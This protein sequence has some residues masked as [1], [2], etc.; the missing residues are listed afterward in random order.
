MGDV[1]DSYVGVGVYTVTSGGTP[2]TTDA[3]F[4]DDITFTGGTIYLG[5]HNLFLGKACTLITPVTASGEPGSIGAGSGYFGFHSSTNGTYNSQPIGRLCREVGPTTLGPLFFPV[6]PIDGDMPG[7]KYVP[8]RVQIM[9]FTPPFSSSTVPF[10]H[11]AVRPVGIQHP[12]NLQDKP[13]LH[14]YWEVDGVGT[15]DVICTKVDMWY[16]QHYV[17]SGS[18]KKAFSARYYDNIVYNNVFGSGWDPTGIEQNLNFSSGNYITVGPSN[19]PSLPAN[20]CVTEFGDY[21][22]G[23]GYPG[24]DPIPVELTSFSARYMDGRVDLNWQTAT[25]LNNF[26]FAIE[27]SVD[28]ENWEE[29]G[30]VQGFGTSSS[31][32]SYAHSDYLRDDLKHLP[33]LAYRLRQMDRD[34][35]TDYSNIVFVKTGELPEGVKLYAAYP[36]PFNPTT[37][38]SFAIGNPADVTLRIYNTLGQNVATLLR[39]SAM[40]A[41][42]HTV[43]FNGDQL[44]SGIYMAVLEANGEVQHQ[45]LVLN[46]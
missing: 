23:F 2:F 15:P 14:L 1:S 18:D 33:Q 38:I 24:G 46:K 29:V 28:K 43:P 9:S 32:K 27:R 21:T 16:H 19:Y 13:S 22:I 41:G 35:T 10:P 39:G 12:A 31:P 40:D 42:L 17:T 6:A 4:D 30:F 44:P 36:N 20:P 45:K 25:E 37:T 26:G 3:R 34:G 5:S 8:C 11:V 7:D